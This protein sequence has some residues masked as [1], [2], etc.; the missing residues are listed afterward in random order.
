MGRIVSVLTADEKA[1]QGTDNAAKHFHIVTSLITRISSS[2][3]EQGKILNY[4]S[5]T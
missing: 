3:L 4:L 2:V 5:D 1:K